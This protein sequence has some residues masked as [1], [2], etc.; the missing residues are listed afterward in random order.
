MRDHKWRIELVRPSTDSR[1]VVTL[2]HHIEWMLT[3]HTNEDQD[4]T[5]VFEAMTDWI[6]SEFNAMF[7]PLNLLPPVST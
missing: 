6:L 1:L 7:L 3:H 5:P 2:P 4:L